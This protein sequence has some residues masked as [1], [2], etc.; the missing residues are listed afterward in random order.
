MRL[1]PSSPNERM[2]EE[3]RRVPRVPMRVEQFRL[4]ETGRVF[5]V[6]DLSHT[7][8]GIRILDPMDLAVLPLGRLVEGTLNLRGMKYSVTARVSHA[9]RES[10]GLEFQELDNA[11]LSGIRNYLD[12]AVLGRELRLIPGGANELWYH[13][14]SGMDYI[15]TMKGHAFTGACL[16]ALESFVRWTREDGVS[17]GIARP[18]RVECGGAGV[19]RIENMLLTRDETPDPS[20]IEIAKT[21]LLSSNQPERHRNAL[22]THLKPRASRGA[23][24]VKKTKKRV[25]R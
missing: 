8:V 18:G 10:V 23:S 19:V 2:F 20:K 13:G 3:K 7:G 4:K 12:P 16:I 25:S 9:R 21:L 15:L 1:V 14:P 24:A 17:T 11:T 6:L 22:L 5:S